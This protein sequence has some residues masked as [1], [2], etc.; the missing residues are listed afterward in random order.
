MMVNVAILL[1]VQQVNEELVADVLKMDAFSWTFMVVSLG[2]ATFLTV[3]SFSRILRGKKHFDPDGT[4]PD[5]PPVSGKADR[6]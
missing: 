5:H 2:A 1:L 4:G 3:W 6:P